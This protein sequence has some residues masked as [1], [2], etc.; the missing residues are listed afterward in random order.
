MSIRSELEGRSYEND[1]N[2]ETAVNEIISSLTSEGYTIVESNPTKP[3]GAYVRIDNGDANKFIS[4]FFTTLDPTDARLG[5]SEAELSPKIL[6]VAPG[7]RLSWQ[8]HHRRAER[9]VFLTNGSY[10]KSSVDTEPPV[11]TAAPGEEIQFMAAERH[12]LIGDATQFTI[13][14][15]IWQHTVPN[16]LSDEDDIVRLQDDYKR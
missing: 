13:V 11:V 15:E 16:Y 12:R 7:E 6:V 14:A 10:Q 5:N 4:D 1:I 8:Y 9:W 3:W 2:K